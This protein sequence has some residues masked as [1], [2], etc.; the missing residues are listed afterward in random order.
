VE[1]DTEDDLAGREVHDFNKFWGWIGTVISLANEDITKVQE[2]TTYPLV[3]VLNYLSYT[4]DLNE[5]KLREQQK[6]LMAQK[7]F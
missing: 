4:K 1:D 5:I 3:F 6:S 2:I 7:R